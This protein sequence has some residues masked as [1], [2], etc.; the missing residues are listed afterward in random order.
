[1]DDV[2][3][4]AT[5]GERPVDR[6]ADVDPPGR[7]A[8]GGGAADGRRAGVA[9]GRMAARISSSS[10]VVARASSTSNRSAKRPG[11]PLSTA[12]ALI[13]QPGADLGGDHRPQRLH[14]GR[15]V[16]PGRRVAIAR[17][18]RLIAAD[19]IAARSIARSTR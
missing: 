19:R 15:R 12:K 4:H 10:L 7:P 17:A 11:S 9:S 18:P 14:A 6:A 5:G 8:S 16:L 13:D 2:E 1:M 3:R